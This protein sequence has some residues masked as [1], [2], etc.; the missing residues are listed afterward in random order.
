MQVDSGH[1]ELRVLCN[2]QE[3]AR[4]IGKHGNVIKGIR[5]ASKAIADFEKRLEVGLEGAPRL[6]QHISLVAG[7]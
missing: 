1:L 2:H 7:P 5:E 3:A 6:I 4:L